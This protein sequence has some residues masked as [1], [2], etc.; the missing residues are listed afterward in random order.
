MGSGQWAVVGL[1]WHVGELVD[2]GWL[3]VGGGWLEVE[4]SD[5]GC[6]DG[7]LARWRLHGVD[8]GSGGGWQQSIGAVMVVVV[9]GR[10]F[11]LPSIYLLLFIN[12]FTNIY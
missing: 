1:A 9:A 4:N 12:Q 8:G 3:S 2:G 5:C 10:L 7:T 6:W 11:E